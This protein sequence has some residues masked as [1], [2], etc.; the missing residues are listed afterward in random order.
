MQTDQ[1]ARMRKLIFQKSHDSV[2]RLFTIWPKVLKNLSY[3][4]VVHVTIADQ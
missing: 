2:G 1:T 4:A 3:I